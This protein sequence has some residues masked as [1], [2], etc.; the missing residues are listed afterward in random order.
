M[1]GETTTFLVLNKL[2]SI[3]MYSMRT[4]SLI[5]ILV[6]CGLFTTQAQQTCQ[7]SLFAWEQVDSDSLEDLE[8]DLEEF[9]RGFERFGKYEGQ[10]QRCYT[11][12]GAES[13][14]PTTSVTI[15]GCCTGG[16]AESLREDFPRIQ[17]CSPLGPD[18]NPP[19]LEVDI[20]SSIET[21]E[22]SSDSPAT[23]DPQSQTG[24]VK[25]I[26]AT[27]GSAFSD[28]RLWLSVIACTLVM[29]VLLS[30]SVCLILRQH[31]KSE[32][33]SKYQMQRQLQLHSTQSNSA[34]NSPLLTQRNEYFA[35]SPSQDEMPPFSEDMEQSLP[36]WTSTSIAAM[37]RLEED[38]EEELEHE[39][40]QLEYS[41]DEELALSR[42]EMD[43]RGYSES[44]DGDVFLESRSTKDESETES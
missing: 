26:A 19:E 20:V 31:E 11:L 2:N 6:S 3:T 17:S 41:D 29:F 27:I 9:C 4:F 40:Q 13:S 24:E 8:A 5:F 38:E 43:K 37:R 15:S 28:W 16:V 14:I 42:D 1:G 32:R 7:A 30:V 12:L 35:S 22:P 44:D 21:E 39:L 25:G 10:G 33:D 34:Y 36:R 18:K 23:Q